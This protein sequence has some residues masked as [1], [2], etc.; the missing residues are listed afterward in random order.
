MSLQV[1]PLHVPGA[2]PYDPPASE[3]QIAS[4]VALFG[5]LETKLTSD[6]AGALLD[7]RDFVL[8]F[9]ERVRPGYRFKDN[10][11]L[12]VP[13]ISY[14]SRRRFLAEPVVQFMRARFDDGAD[15]DE[16][17]T[18]IEELDI[19]DEVMD[20]CEASFEAAGIDVMSVDRG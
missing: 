5:P 17:S 16:L 11:P 14:I 1:E 8:A 7:Y 9:I 13:V 6:Q 10:A 19:F 4:I 2:F 18:V 12:A 15:P 3:A 20:V